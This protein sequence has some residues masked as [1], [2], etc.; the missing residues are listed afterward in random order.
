M[1][2][3]AQR[4]RSL[5]DAEKTAPVVDAAAHARFMNVE[6]LF[7][8]FMAIHFNYMRQADL[9]YAL[10]NKN[11]RMSKLLDAYTDVVKLGSPKW[12]EAALERLGEAYRNFNKGLLDAPMPR[13]LDPEQQDL[14]RTTLENQALPLEDKATDAFEKA[15]QTGQ[16]TGHYSEWVLKAQEYL[17]EY[18]PDSYGD[19]HKPALVDSETSKAI[20]PDLAPAAGSGGY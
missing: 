1:A 8:D 12:T 6:P 19:L 11:A 18:K 20:A 2:E 17:R 7:N 9:V 13:G 3:V 15:V 4:F 10:K 16:K 14:Y 5:P